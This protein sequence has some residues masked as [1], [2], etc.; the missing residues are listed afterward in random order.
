M[1]GQALF[2]SDFDGTLIPCDSFVAVVR[3]I[4]PG[5]R[6]IR[7]LL[8]ASP[9]LA[10][11]KTG[12]ISGGRA[13]ERLFGA[14]FGGM[15]AVEFE[16]ACRHVAG[17]LP[18]PQGP[19]AEDMASAMKE[20]I[21]TAIVSASLGSWIRPWARRYGIE[22]VIAT[23]AEIGADGRLTGRFATPNCYGDEKVRRLSEHYGDILHHCDITVWTDSRSDTPFLSLATH[24][25]LLH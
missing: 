1:R 20:G 9:W 2:L 15:P 17:K 24:P 16:T 7:A 22:T 8:A 18:P 4:V 13:K 11:W 3:A 21:P 14:L 23:E 6:L 25:H 5:G 19:A 12:I 10:A